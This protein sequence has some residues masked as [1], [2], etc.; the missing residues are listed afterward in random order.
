[1]TGVTLARAR[2][3][4][5]VL[6]VGQAATV[7]GVSRSCA[8]ESIRNGTFPAKL[9]TVGRRKKVLTATLL[10]VLEGGGADGP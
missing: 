1:M 10:R 9:I 5:A 7:L 6:D 4:P 2:T 8:Y 3:L